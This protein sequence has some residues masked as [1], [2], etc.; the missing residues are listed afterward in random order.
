MNNP[1][2]SLLHASARP[3]QWHDAMVRWAERC[4]AP[5]NV[6]YLLC[7]DGAQFG[8]FLGPVLQS[9][10]ALRI[11]VWGP[12]R[13]LKNER[14][15]CCV[16]AWNTAAEQSQGGILIN[17]A[18]DYHPPCG[19]DTQILDFLKRA[20]KTPSDQWMLQVDNQD[21]SPWLLAFN[22][23]S[24]A[25]YERLGYFYWPE[26]SGLV[27][28]TDISVVCRRDRVLLDAR[29][30]KFAHRQTAS[31]EIYAQQLTFFERG[32]EI[33]DRRTREGFPPLEGH[34]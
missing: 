10:I 26:Y 33:F 17:I 2:F 24:R 1:I 23:M 15:R 19:W 22:F 8:E 3:H 25:Y 5:Q 29:E 20:G 9:K 4:D 31:D 32:R 30:I 34:K 14:R 18:D 7:V 11:N 13:L 21:A 27:N 6:E 12:F 28:D 16:D